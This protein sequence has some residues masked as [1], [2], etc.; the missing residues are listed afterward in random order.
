MPGSGKT[1]TIASAVRALLAAGRSVLVTA[2]T[3]SAVDNILLKL[4]DAETPILR[5]GQPS[6]VH[7]SVQK[8]LPGG[9]VH[10]DTSAAGLKR[11]SQ[12]ATLVRH[13]LP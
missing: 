10:P 1:S 6:G 8:Y 12:E 2:Y 3:N 5:I 13:S 9:E 4:A 11:L 7:P